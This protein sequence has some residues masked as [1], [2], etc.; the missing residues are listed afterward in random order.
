FNELQARTSELT[1]S[2]DELTA[3]GDVSQAL[4]STLDLET[5]LQTI[6]T[7]ANQ[8]AETAG[9]SSWEYDEERQEFRLRVSRY[10]VENDAE[11][12]QIGVPRQHVPR[13]AHSA[14]RRHRVLG[15]PGRGDVR[16]GQR[17]T[18]R[19]S[20]RHPGVGTASPVAHQRHPRSLEDRG[21]TD[22][23]GGHGLR[24]A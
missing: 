4:G 16:C 22:G 19:I 17:E 3:L 15:G 21:R 6:V 18:D 5:L 10:A 24:S 8:L 1:R 11:P 23:A 7:R 9:C 14:P 2:V 20:R 13:A 12:P